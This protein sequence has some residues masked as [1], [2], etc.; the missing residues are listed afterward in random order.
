MKGRRGTVGAGVSILFGVS[1]GYGS[2]SWVRKFFFLADPEP[3]CYNVNPPRPGPDT[4]IC[5]VRE[6]AA[7][8]E[9][10]SFRDFSSGAVAKKLSDN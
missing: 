7:R 4:A 3:S 1:E 10:S 5:G 6:G 9:A 8:L 2:V